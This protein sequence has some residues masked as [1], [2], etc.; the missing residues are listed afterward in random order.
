LATEAG[1]TKQAVKNAESG[2]E[3]F[4]STAKSI[5]DALSRGYGR[6]IKVSDIEGLK[7]V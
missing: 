5:A 3:I 2:N 6:D 7:V 4:P 1:I